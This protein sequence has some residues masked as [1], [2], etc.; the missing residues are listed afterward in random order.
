LTDLRQNANLLR[1]PP[2]TMS[3]ANG[4]RA[5]GTVRVLRLFSRLNIGGP[6]IHVIL[7]AS[8]LRAK[9][10]ETRLIVGRESPT[11]G[12]L[13]ALA[14]EKCVVCET[15]PALGR[16]IRLLSDWR[17][18]LA[19][20]RIMRDFRPHVVHTHAAKA[21]LLGRIAAR[22]AGVPVVVHTYHGH[23]LRGYFGPLKTRVFRFL[24]QAM[25][26]FTHA[27]V[28]VSDAVKQDLVNLGVAPSAQIRVVP[29]GLELGALAG[30]L[31]R[32][33]LRTDA[34]IPRDAIL[35]GMV[36]RLVPIKDGSTFLA[37]A[38]MVHERRPE[39]R[40]ALIGDG[41]ERSLLEGVCRASS[42]D[43]VVSFL[44][45]RRDLPSVYGDL[46]L[47][48][49][50]SLNEGTPVALIEALAAARPVVATAVGGT[51]DVLAQGAHG[52]LVPPADPKALAEAVLFALDRKDEARRR[53][54]AG[55]AY[56][57]ARHSSERLVGDIDRLYREL[58][59]AR[60]VV[61]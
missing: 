26:R 47:V 28:A 8:G 6:S 46:D 37:A 43:G 9:G 32:G 52:W 42:L 25:A 16:E 58:L 40:F 39:V 49:N 54:L 11:E 31:P 4:D 53:A 24:E 29:L 33:V 7:L 15:L 14:A 45:W 41:E 51:P 21:G 55:Q 5:T 10:Y 57:L 30:E 23:V 17:S 18:L 27:L 56:V 44:G 20:V 12:N 34:G 60:G 61:A 48:V 35:V 36:G 1:G 13:F 2:H 59:A 22:V 38:R 3:G 50:S 19:L